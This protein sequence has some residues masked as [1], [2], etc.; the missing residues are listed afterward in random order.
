MRPLTSLYEIN[1]QQLLFKLLFDRI[2]NF[3]SVQPDSESTFPFQSNKIFVTFQS[4][5]LP[6]APLLREMDMCV[7]TLFVQNLILNNF[8]LNNILI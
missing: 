8:N 5:E 3:D 4:L 2:S 1:S 6:R 7:H